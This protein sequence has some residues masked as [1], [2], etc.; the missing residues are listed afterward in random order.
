MSRKTQAIFLS[1]T[2][3]HLAIIREGKKYGLTPDVIA[4]AGRAVPVSKRGEHLGYAAILPQLPAGY[5]V[6]DA[7]P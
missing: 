3:A 2:S 4:K 7:N 6:E 5:V 1:R